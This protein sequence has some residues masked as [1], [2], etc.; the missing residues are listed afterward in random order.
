MKN[1]INLEKSHRC[2]S[3]KFVR[4][5]NKNHISIKSLNDINITLPYRFL[6]AVSIQKSFSEDYF[7]ELS[8]KEKDEVIKEAILYDNIVKINIA[9]TENILVLEINI[10]YCDTLFSVNLDKSNEETIPDKWFISVAATPLEIQYLVSFL[11]G[12][13]Q[14]FSFS[15]Q[16]NKSK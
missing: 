14:F 16:C 15:M 1:N 5:L 6:K 7:A 13:G 4:F 11:W 10:S 3:D 2:M 12:N 8:D 9:G